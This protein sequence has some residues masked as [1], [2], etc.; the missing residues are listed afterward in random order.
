MT[1]T[2]KAGT[3]Y[4]W[5]GGAAGHVNDWNQ[6][7]NWTPSS[8]YPGSGGSTTDAAVINSATNEP[9]LNI[10]VTIDSL[11]INA[12]AT[13]SYTAGNVLTITG[14]AVIGPSTTGGG[15][16][17][18]LDFSS[19]T[20]NGVD[21]SIGGTIR[22]FGNL[23]L[24]GTGQIVQIGGDMLISGFKA[25]DGANLGSTVSLNGSS[26][27]SINPGNTGSSSYQYDYLAIDNTSVGGVSINT[28]GHLEIDADL[29][30]NGKLNTGTTN[31]RLVGNLSMGANKFNVAGNAEELDLEGDNSNYLTTYQQNISHA[32]TFYFVDV[33][34]QDVFLGG[35]VTIKNRLNF[36][37]DGDIVLQGNNL[38]ISSGGITWG[39]IY[40]TTYTTGEIVTD[41]SS[42]GYLKLTTSDAGILFPV[43]TVS[44]YDLAG[45]GQTPSY[46]PITFTAP[47][48]TNPVLSVR[49][50]TGVT[51]KSG[52]AVSTVVNKTW[53]VQ[54]A[55]TSKT[56]AFETGWADG[57]GFDE[58][59]TVDHTATFVSYRY[60]E[61]VDWKPNTT[62]GKTALGITSGSGGVAGSQDSISG[63]SLAIGTDLHTTVYIATGSSVAA[64]PVTLVSFGAQYQNGHVNLNWTTASEQN[65]AY[66]EIERSIDA[67]S[68]TNIGQVQGHGTTDVY[69]SYVSVDNLAG[70][71]PS[72]SLYYRLKQ[73][74]FNGKFTY[75]MI[76]SVD[77]SN[78]GPSIATY[79]NPTSNILNVNWTSATDDNAVV[80]LVNM[81]GINVYEQNVNGKG[82]IQQKID[83]ST[84]PSGVYYLQIISNN[85]STVN[86]PVYKN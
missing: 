23:N 59:G 39:I 82:L 22:G 65:N 38:D 52:G 48:G 36:D 63:G 60:A 33:Y 78:P 1:L 40:G 77:L 20:G 50:K 29:S 13:L 5:V 72:G 85:S 17:A 46:T 81:S 8:G 43:G 30:G 26:A 49:V 57:S 51:D 58:S 10:S 76:R 84:L 66:F 35:D 25:N 15:T 16:S 80:R 9:T 24:Y 19:G 31:I 55:T 70:V 61:N 79:P 34:N 18:T 2:A 28:S 71:I 14:N 64:L 54:P 37:G 56:F 41:V 12:S 69:N 62:A 42:S 27:Q 45:T 53:V 32:Q 75:S 74:D 47:S 83:M 7:G 4:V 44:N 11:L 21:L 6:S 73:V 68:W 3:R 86:L 67:T